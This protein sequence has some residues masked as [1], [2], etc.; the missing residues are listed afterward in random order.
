VEVPRQPTVLSAEV[1]LVAQ[2]GK[3]IEGA[4]ITAEN[5]R[6]Y[7][8][9]PTGV[10]AAQNYFRKEGFTVGPLG[11]VSFSISGPLSLF[12]RAFGVRIETASDRSAK[13]KGG[14]GEA[15]RALPLT[16]L[17]GALRGFIHAVTFGRPLDFGPTGSYA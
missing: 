13:I 8:P 1:V 12:E 5:V 9:S 3:P 17:P 16:R 10:T 6:E 14:R 15:E 4:I 11:G 2:S 7:T